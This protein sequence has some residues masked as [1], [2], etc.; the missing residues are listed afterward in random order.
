MAKIYVLHENAAWLGP[1][2]TAFAEQGLPYEE[3]FLN[4]GTV[5]LGAVPP[6]GVF[7]NRMSASSYTRDHDRA[8]ELTAAVLAWLELHDR[9]V[10][11]S[12]RALELEISKTRQYAALNAQGIRTPRSIVAVGR[13]AIATA[14]RAFAPGPVMLKPGRG[15]KGHGVRLFADARALIAHVESD[16][17]APPI[18]GVALVQ[19]YVA[20][21]EPFITRAEF[22]G[23]RFFYA[24]R[25]D[26]SNGFE[27]CPADVCAVEGGPP[28]PTFTIV[29]R[30]DRALIAPY[31]RFLAANGIEVAGIEFITDADGVHYTYDVN[32]NTN[33][34]ADAEAKAGRSGMGALAAFL[35][36]ELARLDG[37][38]LA[39]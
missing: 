36:E 35:G 1:L 37:V 15:G 21:P 18:D 14:A 22:I 8:P 13:S 31:E 30:I 11:N 4:E 27:L 17:Y 3:W 24:V 10:I 2:R 32:T 7:Y 29:D 28:V 20:A 6:D 12:S 39:I 5:D 19:D 26:T 25:V 34:N 16:A 9:R 33:Y 23:G 38:R